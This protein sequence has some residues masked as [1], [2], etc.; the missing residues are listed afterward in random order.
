MTL[1]VRESPNYNRS[2]ADIGNAPWNLNSTGTTPGGLSS[3]PESVVK[4]QPNTLTCVEMTGI[5]NGQLTA[6]YGRREAHNLVAGTSWRPRWSEQLVLGTTSS[7]PCATTGDKASFYLYTYI[8]GELC[9]I[10]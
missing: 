9:S 7:A 6:P 10:V 1:Q 3:S 2:V 4:G 8:E 5:K